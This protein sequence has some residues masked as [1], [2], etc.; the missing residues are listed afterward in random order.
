[1]TRKLLCVATN[2]GEFL[3][4][5]EY[6]EKKRGEIKKKIEKGI[7]DTCPG[8]HSPGAWPM[9]SDAGGVNP[10]QIPEAREWARKNGIA[11]DFTDTGEAI[12]ES[13]GARKRYLKAMGLFCRKSG[14]GMFSRTYRQE[15]DKVY[16]DPRFYTDR[17][18]EDWMR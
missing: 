13:D 7:I 1:M 4:A 3:S 18:P 5:D 11:V 17:N 2:D 15:E 8:G 16:D 6:I 14:D 10:D 12:L 9:V